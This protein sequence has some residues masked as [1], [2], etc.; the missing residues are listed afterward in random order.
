MHN[1]PTIIWG[2]ESESVQQGIR[3]LAASGTVYQRGGQLVRIGAQVEEGLFGFRGAKIETVKADWLRVEF[4][5][6]ACF[7]EMD[8]SSFVSLEQVPSEF[9]RLVLASNDYPGIPV[10]TGIVQVPVYLGQGRCLKTMG[11]DAQSGLFF[12]PQHSNSTWNIPD[13]P[14]K[15]DAALAAEI[16]FGVVGDFPFAASPSPG[17][18]RAA[19]LAWL[20]TLSARYAIYGPVPFALL[21]ASSPGAGKNLLARVTCEIALGRQIAIAA[22]SSDMEELRRALL[23][24]MASGSRLVWLDE[25]KSPF[26]GGAINIVVTAW[27]S[28]ADRAIRTSE[29]KEVPATTCLL[30]TGNNIELASDSNRRAILI[31]LEPQTD[32]AHQRDGFQHEDLIAWVCERREILLTCALT[33]LRAHHLAGAPTIIRPLL[34]VFECWDQTVRQAVI[35]ATGTDPLLTQL[36]SAKTLDT[37]RN[38]WIDIVLALDQIYGETYWSAKD[39]LFTLTSNPDFAAAQEGIEALTGSTRPTAHTFS[40]SILRRRRDSIEAGFRLEMHEG[41]RK[42]GKLYRLVRSSQNSTSGLNHVQITN[43]VPAGWGTP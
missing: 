38:A 11:Y 35:W 24:H 21:D 4:S 18:N 17:A 1:K 20:L 12:A 34:G 3:V 33:I 28:Y 36:A 14:T 9:S 23:P 19:W 31:R 37:S 10:L 39:A 22:C 29:I 27:P 32:S 41:R 26:G 30:A 40:F 16:L 42:E 6:I 7:G 43:G 2:N 25:V 8:G 15:M 13:A 5:R